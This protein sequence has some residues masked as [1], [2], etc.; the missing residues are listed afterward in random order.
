[1]RIDVE[2]AFGVD[3]KVDQAVAGEQIEHVV[4]EPDAG[5]R[6]GLAGA[7]EVQ[8]QADLRLFGDARDFCVSRVALL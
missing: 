1:M 2:V 8:R 4:E 3:R 7:V 5:A 6:R